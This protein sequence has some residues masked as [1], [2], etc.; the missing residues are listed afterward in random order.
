MRRSL[1]KILAM[2]AAVGFGL[3]ASLTL[4]APWTPS[5]AAAFGRGGHF[6]GFGGGHIGGFGG[7]FGGFGGG[8][9]G[10]FGHFGGFP[11]VGGFGFRPFGGVPHAFGF[12]H[13][14][15]LPHSFAFHHHGRFG[16]Y[17]RI[18]HYHH[19][20]HG[21]GHI[22]GHHF[23]RHFGGRHI[24]HHFAG[25]RF[26]GHHLAGHVGHFASHPGARHFAQAGG[27]GAGTALGRHALN[28]NEHG[29]PGDLSRFRRRGFNPNAFG[30]LA[31]W[32]GFGGDFLDYGWGDWGSGWG[33]WAG[34]V[35]WPYFY[36]DVLTFVL[37]PYDYYNPFFA[38]D[39]D[40]LL[41]S[42]LWPGPWGAPSYGEAHNVYDIYGAPSQE[43]GGNHAHE[44][45]R[46][47]RGY[48]GAEQP[49]A[50]AGATAAL[51][52]GGL[53]P[54]VPSLPIDNI[55]KAARPNEAQIAM[56]KDLRAASA[57]ADEELRASC[58]KEVP[59]T[60]VGRLDAMTQ[61]M[62]AMQQAV[63]T[64]R[65]PL[66]KFFDSLDQA[67]K[68]RVEALRRVGEAGENSLA[69]LCS[70]KSESF[71]SLPI[72]RIEELIHP[73]GKQEAAFESLKTASSKA[74]NDLD[75]SCPTEAPK[76]FTA[77]FDAVSK[78]LGALVTALG[79]VRPALA[80]FYDS[81]TDE[82]KARFNMMGPTKPK[83]AS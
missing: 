11:H 33:Y 79:E 80:D 51:T 64:V 36:G 47:R 77:R 52:C 54:G 38:Y 13:F 34:P 71:T 18:G 50:N 81:L 75:A 21:F 27:L 5:E 56:L 39:L 12:H 41:A 62:Q 6:G 43:G 29:R 15:G 73:T 7:H 30:S 49:S 3:Q 70:R 24:I 82:Q 32:E 45:W 67:Q 1:A 25:R 57:K 69:S 14:G 16:H 74:A 40:F 37:W 53:A 66:E 44:H 76:T 4:V 19:M 8:R 55:E 23:A 61:R 28:N 48:A 63:Q 2:G 46:H 35:F 10:G 26:A 42:A 60:P 68:E 59:L 78:R 72:Q 58:P 65:A 83:G 9:F 20:A 17:G 22:G 31:A